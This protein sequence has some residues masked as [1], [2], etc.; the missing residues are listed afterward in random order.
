DVVEAIFIVRTQA[1]DVVLFHS[2][3]PGMAVTDLVKILAQDQS[4]QKTRMVL[5]GEENCPDITTV[6]PDKF[7]RPQLAR[8]L[9]ECLTGVV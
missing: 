4:T 1:P 2:A 8:A 5:V 3:L 7:D 6:L 9:Q